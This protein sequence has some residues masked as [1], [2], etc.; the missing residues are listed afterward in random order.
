MNLYVA[1]FETTVY[2]FQKITQVW[3][4]AICEVGNEDENLVLVDNSIETFFE[5]VYKLKGNI[6]I[7]F[8][9][10]KF[11]GSF[12]L[13]YMLSNPNEFK[14]AI[15]WIKD[16][17]NVIPIF[18][19]RNILDNGE[20]TYLISDKGLF[21]S[22]LLKKNGRTIEF[23][24]SYKLIPA[25]VAEIGKTYSDLNKLDLDYKKIRYP[26]WKITAKERK[27][28]CR[29]V[30]IMSKG[31]S[32]F[33]SKGYT[34]MTIG[35][36]AMQEFRKSDYFLFNNAFGFSSRVSR[37]EMFEEKFPNLLEIFNSEDNTVWDYIVK[38]YKGAWCYVNKFKKGK[39]IY[40]KGLTA[41]V[42][43]LYPYVMHSMSGNYYPVGKPTFWTGQPDFESLQDKY[44]FI[45]I[46]CDFKLKRGYLPTIQIKG[47]WLYNPREFLEDNIP[48]VSGVKRHN[49]YKDGVKLDTRVTLTLTMTDF[50]LFREHYHIFNLE[51]ISGCYFQKEIG[52]F[53]GYIDRWMYEKEHSKGLERLIAKLFQNNLYG[54][55]ATSPNSSYKYCYLEEGVLKFRTIEEREK[56]PG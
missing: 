52:I 1:D 2:K 55:F 14:P 25:S 53:D 12:I 34:K 42:N 56:K 26:G 44:W 19:R 21:Y 36:C 11:D 41:D 10:L 16:N 24:D 39:V 18:K 13:N 6:K 20:F 23:L 50:Y 38:S 32:L 8:H 29:D 51:Y 33:F 43:S 46:K 15:F 9:N 4:S 28:I 3:A 45:R 17:D 27:Y 40:R 22:I 7:Y 35:A 31:L 37:K 30:I 49:I 5:R 54:K 48:T 47:N